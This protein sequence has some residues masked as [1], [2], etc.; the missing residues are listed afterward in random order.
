MTIQVREIQPEVAVL[1]L[2]GRL[3]LGEAC[4]ALIQKVEE[5]LR[6]NKA[7]LVLEMAALEFMDS[8]GLGT[9]VACYGK[10]KKAG[11]GLVLAAPQ[12]KVADTFKITHMDS[13]VKSF[14]TAEAAAES[15]QSPAA[16]APPTA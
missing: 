12:K 3:T 9:V 10:A 14:P 6:A 11:G 13:V 2:A 15:F 1:E 5:I 8:A 4:Q 7:C 16:S